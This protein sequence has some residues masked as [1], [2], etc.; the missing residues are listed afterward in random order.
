MPLCY[1]GS[2]GSLHT[3]RWVR[4]FA[5]RG[6]ETHLIA[7]TVAT[8]GR[9]PTAE[10]QLGGAY[11]HPWRRIRVGIPVLDRATNIAI[12]GPRVFRMRSL[13]GR[14][15]PSVLHAH[16]LNEQALFAALTG[17]RPF[18]ATAWGSDVLLNPRQSHLLR[19]AVRFIVRRADLLT[20]DA[21]HMRDALIQLGANPDKVRIVNFGVDVQ[22]FAPTCRDPRLRDRLEL[23][24]SP[25]ILSSRRLE[26]IYDVRS[27]VAAI[28]LVVAR[29]PNAKFVIAG[30]GSEEPALRQVV[31]RLK[32]QD[33]VR[34]VGWLTED[35]LP[36]YIASCDIYVSTALSDGGIAS[37]TAEAMSCGLPVIV[38]DVGDNR[39][40]IQ[41]GRQGFVVAT[42]N[43]D[44]LAARIVELIDDAGRRRQLG[45]NGRELIARENNW[46]LEMEKM[47]SVYE[48]LA[49]QHDTVGRQAPGRFA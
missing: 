31:E 17:Y 8:P 18:V 29:W 12:C 15:R 38:T 42:K 37:S 47:A 25:T 13:L 35:E 20:C 4:Y 3:E 36:R 28:P 44:Q 14:L 2:L 16:Y 43:S 6:H 22:R 24:D 5:A 10:P 40:W 11:V 7:T 46:A 21:L 19:V 33:S 30:S 9:R 23:G 49:Q 41:D 1:V 39:E 45:A 27:L 32:L 34:F 48:K 26:P